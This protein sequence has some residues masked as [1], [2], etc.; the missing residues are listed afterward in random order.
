MKTNN[1]YNSK[2]S[3][4]IFDKNLATAV[5]LQSNDSFSTAIGNN[6]K[7]VVLFLETFGQPIE[8]VSSSNTVLYKGTANYISIPATAL[9]NCNQIKIR[10]KG[11]RAIR[12]V[13]CVMN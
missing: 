6:L 10:N 11:T 7:T 5:L 1:N 13:E 3:T 4:L 12:I 2:D 9:K 8:V